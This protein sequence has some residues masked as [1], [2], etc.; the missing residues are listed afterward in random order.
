M[1]RGWN[2]FLERYFL[3]VCQCTNLQELERVAQHI[4]PNAVAV[5]G[6]DATPKN[7]KPTAT[8]FEEWGNHEQSVVVTKMSSNREPNTPGKWDQ[9]QLKTPG[10]AAFLPSFSHSFSHSSFPCF[11]AF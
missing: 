4:P 7:K 6:E 1:T 9:H 2:P 8:G 10:S 5:G 11:F 3:P